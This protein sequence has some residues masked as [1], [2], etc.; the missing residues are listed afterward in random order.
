MKNHQFSKYISL[1][2]RH[3]PEVLGITLEATG[4]ANVNE[5][6]RKMQE[7]GMNVDLAQLKE[8][9]AKDNKQR[10]AFNADQTKIRANQG[11]S[12]AV[13]LG[14]EPQTPPEFLYHGTATRFLASIQ[15]TGLESRSRQYV[16]LSDNLETAQKVGR[17]HGKPV[18][19]IVK[20]KE[21]HERGQHF[22]LSENGVWL[23]EKVVVEFIKFP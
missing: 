18:I 13:D 12:I 7:K 6:L 3:K 22:F 20:A 5:M 10:Y 8:V 19:L 1:I 9:V 11:H 15:K 4:W 2:L 21:L 14:F 16:H 17:R 23:T